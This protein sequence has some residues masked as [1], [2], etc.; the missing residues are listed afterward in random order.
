[1]LAAAFVLVGTANAER[2]RKK[3]P[4]TIDFVVLDANTDGSVSVA[5]VQYVDDLRA[6]FASL[7]ANRD[8][9]LSPVEFAKWSRAGNT[10]DALPLDPSTGPSGSSGAQHM[11]KAK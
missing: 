11:P 8:E 5:E 10:K 7:D 4:T 9:K 1:L 2:R 3:T 6:D